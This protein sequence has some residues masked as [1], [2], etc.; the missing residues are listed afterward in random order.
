M[1]EGR[2]IA[3]TTGC[4]SLLKDVQR[5]GVSSPESEQ[6][7]CLYRD[8]YLI[9]GGTVVTVDPV[10]NLHPGQVLVDEGTIVAVGQVDETRSGAVSVDATGMIVMP[11]WSTRISTC[12]RAWAQS[13]PRGTSTS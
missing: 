11:G 6:K 1:G 10:I 12:G 5:V 9:H 7:Q 3:I 13:S 8:K 2:T 4:R